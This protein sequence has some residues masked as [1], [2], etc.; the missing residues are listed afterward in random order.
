MNLCLDLPL[1]I[2]IILLELMN[3]IKAFI[4]SME[5]WTRT[6]SMDT[7]QN[8]RNVGTQE[9]KIFSCGGSEVNAVESTRPVANLILFLQQLQKYEH[10]SSNDF[11]IVKCLQLE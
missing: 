8:E 9:M 10:A 2:G 11:A 7:N 5:R 4:P 1:R 3:R 6:E